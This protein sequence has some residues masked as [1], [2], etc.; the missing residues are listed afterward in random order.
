MVFSSHDTGLLS[1]SKPAF[2]KP[3][4]ILFRISSASSPRR[5]ITTALSFSSAQSPKLFPTDHGGGHST[6]R[7]PAAADDPRAHLPTEFDV[8]ISIRFSAAVARHLGACASQLHDELATVT[9]RDYSCAHARTRACAY[10]STRARARTHADSLR[11]DAAA[12]YLRFSRGHYRR[13]LHFWHCESLSLSVVVVVSVSVSVAVVRRRP[14]SSSLFDV[15]KSRNRVKTMRPDLAKKKQQQ[16]Q[17]ANFA[18]ADPNG[19]DLNNAARRKSANGNIDGSDSPV[20]R[21][22]TPSLYNPS[23][24]VFGNMDDSQLGFN[25]G[26]ADN[27]SASPLNGDRHLDVPQTHE[28]LIAAN[29]AL[30]TRVSELELINELFRGR[31]SQMEQDEASARRGQEISGKAEAQ[32]RSQ[33][34]A[35]NKQLED[36][37]RRENNLKRRLDEMELELKEAKEAA[38]SSSE[39]GRAA[40][41]L[42]VADMVGDSEVSTPQSTT[43]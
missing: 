26:G 8:N 30:K 29:S 3:R 39:S 31:L 43:A 40:K 35:S 12:A 11:A 42:R 7:P 21:T 13:R 23:L 18:G 37:H 36:S 4:S 2:P 15:I 32:L 1:S 33:L 5:S 41:K 16:Q 24:P 9:N 20:S 34:E 10:D 28:Q 6:F 19:M 14:P 22:A 27:R 17:A 25:V 38:D